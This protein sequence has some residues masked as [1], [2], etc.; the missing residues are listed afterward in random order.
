MDY[1]SGIVTGMVFGTFDRLHEGHH[2]FLR[3]ARK[4]C[5]QLIA[6]VAQ[7][8]IVN[9]LKGHNPYQSIKDRIKAVQ[10]LTICKMVVPG[11]TI[12]EQWRPIKRYKPGV[13]ILGYDQE[14]LGRAVRMFIRQNQKKGTNNY[15]STIL[16]I[17]LK[18][19]QPHKYKS[20]YLNHH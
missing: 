10:A 18:A 9:A 12:L 5:D 17:S 3:N 13:I 8:V 14:S 2:F 4:Q 20:S 1:V 16:T 6:V 19:F 11:D 15:Q 7:D